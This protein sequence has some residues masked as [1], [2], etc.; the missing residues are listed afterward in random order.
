[1]FERRVTATTYASRR[2]H[3]LGRYR[4]MTTVCRQVL[5]LHVYVFEHCRAYELHRTNRYV[6]GIY[7][8]RLVYQTVV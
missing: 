4:T 5:M 2:Y 7:R 1:M 8:C 6:I 3:V